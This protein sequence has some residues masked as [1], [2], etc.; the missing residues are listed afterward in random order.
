LGQVSASSQ[1]IQYVVGLVRE[2]NA[3][4]L[5][6]PKKALWVDYWG[7]F[8]SML[9]FFWNDINNALTTADALDMRI[10]SDATASGGQ[11]YA[12]I[13]AM[14]LRQ[15]YAGNEFAG[16]KEDPLYYQKE[17]SS[18]GFMQTVDVI[19]PATPM[20]YY[21]NIT[22]LK[23]LLDPLFYQMEN[24]VWTRPFAMHDIGGRFPNATGQG[25]GGDMPVEESGNM[26]MMVADI[27]F[28]PD[29]PV[30]EA[31]SYGQKHYPI[32]SVWADYLL[33]NCLYPVDQLSTD[34]FIGPTELNS[35]LALKGILGNGKT[36][37]D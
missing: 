9:N 24:G 37:M 6:E 18:G 19:Y 35:G 1:R 3:N 26:L 23:L 4:F 15:A 8:D 13:L 17:I 29:T 25:Y 32:L 30:E 11:S 36:K 22:Y 12:D 28:H 16:T 34:D 7:T 21:L 33:N 27:I 20:F 10:L 5:G 31:R 14:S 2:D